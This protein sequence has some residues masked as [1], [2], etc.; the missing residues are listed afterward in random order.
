MRLTPRWSRPAKRAAQLDAVRMHLNAGLPI[1]LLE[2][3]LPKETN[4]DYD[5][6]LNSLIPF[7]KKMLH[8]TGVFLPFGAVIDTRG[9]LLLEGSFPGESQEIAEGIIDNLISVYKKFAR[10]S[11]IRSCAYCADVKFSH[12]I[13]GSKS[14]AILVSLENRYG[15][16]FNFYVP[17]KKKFFRRYTF[18][19]HVIVSMPALIF[20]D[21]LDAS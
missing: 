18:S 7:A 9:K 2:E 19:K 16:P 21:P 13:S 1:T 5:K 12:P 17:Y 8:E 20:P 3:I 11:E 10:T 15:P 6:L 4:E 14:D